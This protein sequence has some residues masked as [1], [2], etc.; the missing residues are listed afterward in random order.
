[1]IHFFKSIRFRI[2]LFLIALL[3]GIM[4]YAVFVGGY[5]ISAVGLFKTMTAPLQNLSN[6]ISERVEYGLDLYRNAENYYQENRELRQEINKIHTQLADYEET[7][8]ELE[9]LEAF[10]GIKEKHS[11]YSMTV[12]FDVIGY[13][14]N[15]IYLSFMI[16]GGSEDGIGLYDTV[17]S[18][19]GL[20]GVITELG[21]HVSTVT[22]ILSPELSVAACTSSS[23][24][25]GVLTGSVAL[26]SEGLCKLEYLEKDTDLKKEKIIL[27]TGENGLFPGGYVIGYVKDVAMD[28]TGLTAYASIEPASDLKNLSM[29]VVITDFNGKAE[30]T[31]AES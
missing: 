26:A 28:D 11:D 10:I 25:K 1:M 31:D 29:V 8:A 30:R 19:L 22:T 7:K 5:T 9:R 4:L 12:P 27:T 17:V 13:V 3:T 15:D 24:E 18:D 21:E 20:V 23:R 14:T 16:D 6:A 2:M